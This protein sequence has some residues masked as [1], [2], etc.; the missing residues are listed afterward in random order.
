[1]KSYPSDPKLIPINHRENSQ[2]YEMKSWFQLGINP[3]HAAIKLVL[4]KV[5]TLAHILKC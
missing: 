1:M 5:E 4:I 3:D 2:H